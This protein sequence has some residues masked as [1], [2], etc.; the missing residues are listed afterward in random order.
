TLNGGLLPEGYF[1]LA[2]QVISGPIPGV[3]TLQRLPRNGKG[4]GSAR[5]GGVALVAAPP[6]ARFVI[7]TALE[8]YVAKANRIVIRHRLGKVVAVIE[9]VSPGNKTSQHALQAFTEKSYE[10]LQQGIH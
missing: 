7:S 10:L 3:V 8:M 1:A 5:T 9:I 2:E 6:R 4:N